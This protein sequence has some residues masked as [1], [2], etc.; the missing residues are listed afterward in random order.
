VAGV[1]NATLT[2]ATA[3][4]HN[5]QGEDPELVLSAIQRVITVAGRNAAR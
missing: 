5:M 2:V 1:N 3:V 4:G